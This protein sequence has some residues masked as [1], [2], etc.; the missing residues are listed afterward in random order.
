MITF[1][2][3]GMPS[4]QGSKRAFVAKGRAIIKDMGGTKSVA[5]RDSVSAKALELAAEHGCLDG[6]LR[7]EVLFR[8]PMPRSRTKAQ[9][10]AV[11]GWK[12]TAPDSSKLLR[13]LEDGLQAGG[14]ITDD[15]RIVEHIVRKV[16]VVDAWT[17]AEVQLSKLRPFP[18]RTQIVSLPIDQGLFEVSA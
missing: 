8:F 9:R 2:V 12:T 14:L 1:D 18:S 16:E 13:A 10:A 4:P 6:P 7:L 5:W 17:G 15:A 3:L 11:Y